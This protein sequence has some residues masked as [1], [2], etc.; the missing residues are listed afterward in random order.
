MT[1]YETAFRLQHD[2]PFNE[3]SRQNPELV[4]SSWCNS[5]TDVMEIS[6]DDPAA[7]EALQKDLKSVEKALKTKI[8]RRSNSS[9]NIQ[10]VIQHCGCENVPAP[11]SPVFEKNNCLE[12]QPTIYKGGWEYYRLISFSEKDM[13]KVFA[14]I[15]PYCK[16]EIISRRV[17]PSGAVKET[18]LVSTS[19]LFGGLTRKQVQALVFA[20]ENGYYQVPKRVTT[21]EMASKLRLPRTT[22][23]EH[24]RK[25]EGKVLRSMAPYISLGPAR[26][27]DRRGEE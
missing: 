14:T 23:E 10:I 16:V 2:C 5:E 11:V 17:I 13:R 18:M 9:R 3:L 1:L 25:A 22:Y 7:F 6:A 21:E 15:E 27:P 26:S 20:L 24:L 8:T 19:S 4:I 12:L